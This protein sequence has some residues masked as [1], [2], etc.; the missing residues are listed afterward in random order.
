VVNGSGAR[1]GGLVVGIAAVLVFAVP[2]TANGGG[3]NSVTANPANAWVMAPDAAMLG[4]DLAQTTGAEVLSEA[5]RIKYNAAQSAG[6]TERAKLG[7]AVSSGTKIKSASKIGL[8]VNTVAAAVGLAFIFGSD[9][10]LPVIGEATGPWIGDPNCMRGNGAFSDTSFCGATTINL[11]WTVP[12]PTADMKVAYWLVGTGSMSS[13]T[14]YSAGELKSNNG[15]ARPLAGQ[16]VD[17]WEIRMATTNANNAIPGQYAVV[18]TIMVAPIGGPAIADPATPPVQYPQSKVVTSA[19]C[20][21]GAGIDTTITSETTFFEAI[22]GST[23]PTVPEIACP[24]G[25]WLKSAQTDLVTG[26]AVKPLTAPYVAPDW[27]ADQAAQ[28][29][30]CAPVGAEICQL[31]IWRLAPAPAINCNNIALGA[32]PL[33]AGHPCAQW[34]SDPARSSTY[35]CRFG[36]NVLPFMNCEPFAQTFTTGLITATPVAETPVPLPVPGSGTITSPSVP[37]GD[38]EGACWPSGWGAFNPASWVML[39]VQ[40]ALTWAF[41]PKVETMTALQT[42][43]G[44]DLAR[45]G[46]P[47]LAGAVAVPLTSVPGGSGCEG[48]EVTFEAG[49]Y[50][51]PVHPFSACAEPLRTAALMTHAV[52]TIVIVVGGGLALLRLIGAGFGFN[53]AFRGGGGEG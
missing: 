27:V 51:F 22:P 2:I 47:A 53:V 36:S 41:V 46:I 40:C 1:R 13:S 30:E 28:F 26:T 29:P 48:P 25:S 12:P 5:E 9:E 38:Q 21:N 20:R 19:V 43:I 33:G 45:T 50:A 49:E 16:P 3:L 4:A 35:Q 11:A 52:F 15:Q 34:A 7:N 42:R 44:A 10:E 18:A 23:T 32:G 17:V 37:Q 39:P 31:A 14:S 8:I 6:I 24:T